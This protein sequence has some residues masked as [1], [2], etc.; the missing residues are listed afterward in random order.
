MAYLEDLSVPFLL[1]GTNDGSINM[2]IRQ[3]KNLQNHIETH[4]GIYA[5]QGLGTLDKPSNFSTVDLLYY[6]VY[7]DYRLT[8][9]EAPSSDA[10]DFLKSKQ[11][12]VPATVYRYISAPPQN[13]KSLK[14][15]TNGRFLENYLTAEQGN[16]D[17]LKGIL[18]EGLSTR[19]DATE[20]FQRELAFGSA[21]NKFHLPSL[22]TLAVSTMA[23]KNTAKQIRELAIEAIDNLYTFIED[24][25]TEA[26]FLD[27]LKNAFDP[28]V[29]PLS[30]DP[31]TQKE[32]DMKLIHA[33]HDSL[34]NNPE[35]LKLRSEHPNQTPKEADLLDA[36]K[37][38]YE[39]DNGYD[40]A[41]AYINAVLQTSLL[42]FNIGMPVGPASGKASDIVSLAPVGSGLTITDINDA[43]W[44]ISEA[45]GDPKSDKP[46]GIFS[47]TS[48]LGTITGV[49]HA[50]LQTRVS[51]LEDELIL[52]AAGT[53]KRYLANP[54]SLVFFRIFLDNLFT[55]EAVVYASN[56]IYQPRLISKGINTYW[57]NLGKAAQTYPNMLHILE[58]PFRD[59]VGKPDTITTFA[60]LRN[61]HTM[62][63]IA[64]LDSINPKAGVE[65]FYKED[66]RLSEV[67]WLAQALTDEGKVVFEQKEKPNMLAQ[68][69]YRKKGIGQGVD[70]SAPVNAKT[71][72]YQLDAPILKD[73]IMKYDQLFID[74]TISNTFMPKDKR[75][76]SGSGGGA[77]V[78]DDEVIRVDD[79]AKAVWSSIEGRSS[80]IINR[81]NV[82]PHLIF[83]T[84][85]DRISEKGTQVYGVVD[86]Y[87]PQWVGTNTAT[88]LSRD[89]VELGEEIDLK[90]YSDRMTEYIKHL[91][92][93]YMGQPAIA[94]VVLSVLG[95][96]VIQVEGNIDNLRE[97][98]IARIKSQ[99]KRNMLRGRSNRF[100]AYRAVICVMRSE[101]DIP[102]KFREA[103]VAQALDESQRAQIKRTFS[104]KSKALVL[105]ETHPEFKPGVLDDESALFDSDNPN[106]LPLP[107]FYPKAG[108]ILNRDNTEVEDYLESVI[109]IPVSM[110]GRSGFPNRSFQ[111]T[112]SATLTPSEVE[113]LKERLLDSD[114]QYVVEDI[115][116]KGETKR[117]D[118]RDS[119]EQ[120]P[121]PSVV[122]HYRDNLGVLLTAR[123]TNG[124]Y[125]DIPLDFVS[126]RDITSYNSILY[127]KYLKDRFNQQSYVYIPPDKVYKNPGT[128][129]AYEPSPGPPGFRPPVF[130]DSSGDP[131]DLTSGT[132]VIVYRG[133]LTELKDSL[134]PTPAPPPTPKDPYEH[135]PIAQELEEISHSISHAGTQN[136]EALDRNTGEL[137]K[138]ATAV[139]GAGSKFADAGASF[140]E[141]GKAF[142]RAGERFTEAGR[143]Y[144]LAAQAFGEIPE[145]LRVALTEASNNFLTEMENRFDTPIEDF[146]PK[147]HPEV[148]EAAIEVVESMEQSPIEGGLA[149]IQN[150]A[151]M[152]PERAYMYRNFRDHLQDMYLDDRSSDNFLSAPANKKTGKQVRSWVSHSLGVALAAHPTDFEI[153]DEI[154]NNLSPK[155]FKALLWRRHCIGVIMFMIDGDYEQSKL[156]LGIEDFEKEEVEVI[157]ETP[158]DPDEPAD[159]SADE[160]ADKPKK[161]KKSMRERVADKGKDMAAKEIAK[162]SDMSVEEARKE[163]D[164]LSMDEAKKVFGL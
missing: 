120:K 103:F 115:D 150:I 62:A 107:D 112:F 152:L 39:N 64:N 23:I 105:P 154:A 91:K 50:F 51:T 71:V 111:A 2:A 155:E 157:E 46:T 5:S 128:Y 66:L 57:D 78:T 79:L 35:Y 69:Q 7:G 9:T 143:H 54:V 101:I 12:G 139:D 92:S 117:W 149:A 47:I 60:K 146:D 68:L 65:N 124:T 153:T 82:Q 52:E 10:P 53:N 141:A 70:A 75:P 127:K 159:E 93:V 37:K 27:F 163:L 144:E 48:D 161:K 118:G 41:K 1:G 28:T 83:E 130:S 100:D 158:A 3:S 132:S 129:H 136:L 80:D 89:P 147:D 8:L 88:K 25:R 33:L 76:K 67:L 40:V 148:G 162:R 84:L 30:S 90:F 17:K 20:W 19:Q 26:K 131:F 133:S 61:T 113:T 102:L 72:F 145:A 121:H 81:P 160:S 16:E 137:T 34:V 59:V 21:A 108:S 29:A 6:H 58:A 49:S 45:K 85:F 142:E 110:G 99:A 122:A 87:P 164:N 77:P 135:E 156:E 123:D 98:F 126:G 42:K 43:E 104:D 36:C 63:N 74:F 44:V 96:I 106:N 56:V 97:S 109:G 32:N 13:T 95:D 73:V 86:N 38:S 125:P 114:T 138:I 22:G 15:V 140:E 31:A 116:W 14:T 151:L 24:R 94:Q 11:A 55:F 119:E 4:Y 18:T 134:L